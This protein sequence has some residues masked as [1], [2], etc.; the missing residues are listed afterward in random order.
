MEKLTFTQMGT[1]ADYITEAGYIDYTQENFARAHKRIQLI[2]GKTD[3][4]EGIKTL[5]PPDLSEQFRKKQIGL[6]QIASLFLS[7]GSNDVYYINRGESK[8]IRTKAS[9]LKDKIR[10]LEPV[11]AT[12]PYDTIML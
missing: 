5:L 8:R 3:A 12:D 6:G 11:L 2:I 9:E 10:P 4:D 1:V 7:R